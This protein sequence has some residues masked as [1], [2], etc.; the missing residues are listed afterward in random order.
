MENG[1]NAGNREGYRN[2]RF[3]SQT[4][5]TQAPNGVR[6]ESAHRAQCPPS[7]KLA[8]ESVESDAAASQLQDWKEAG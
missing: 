1:G 6:T 8:D 7:R 5:E 3:L 4:R 2:R